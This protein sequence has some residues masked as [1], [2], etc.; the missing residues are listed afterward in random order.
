MTQIYKTAA[1]TRNQPECG[2]KNRSELCAQCVHRARGACTCKMNVCAVRE[3]KPQ[4][5]WLHTQL[6]KKQKIKDLL[7]TPAWAKERGKWTHTGDTPPSFSL[8]LFWFSAS[9]KSRAVNQM[10]LKSEPF[11]PASRVSSLAA[12][13]S[14]TYCLSWLKKKKERW[15]SGCASSVPIIRPTWHGD[16]ATWLLLC[17]GTDLCQSPGPKLIRSIQFNSTKLLLMSV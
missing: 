7:L 11:H 8:L 17:T 13:K 16:P 12:G 1:V 9:A 2:E 15:C 5:E 6:I 4:M 10:W 3:N 14:P